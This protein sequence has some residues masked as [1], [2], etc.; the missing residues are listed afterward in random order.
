MDI[1]RTKITSLS[2]KIVPSKVKSV[3]KD[4]SVVEYLAELHSKFA[5]V[6]ID[7]AANNISIICKRFYLLRIL[8]ELG[9]ADTPS[10]TYSLSQSTALSII[11]HNTSLCESYHLKVTDKMKT[12]PFIYW[13]PKMHYSPS[14]CRFILASS[15]CSTKPLSQTVSLIFKKIFK[16]IQSFHQRSY[17]YRN[18]N[19]FWVVENSKPV[20][21]R[22]IKLNQ[23]NKAKSISTFDFSTLYTK[24]PHNNLVEVLNSLVDFV[25]DGGLKTVGGNRKYLTVDGKKCYFANTNKIPQSYTKAQIHMMVEHLIT[26]FFFSFGNLVFQQ[27]IGIPMG[28][29]PA[30]FWAN[31]YLYHFE[32]EFVLKL[33]RIDRYRGFKFKHCFRFIDDACSINDSDEF[34]KSYLE[35]YPP[36]LQLKCEH[37]GTHA[38]F[39]ELDISIIDG[40][41]VYKLYDKRDAFPFFIV[42]MPDLSGNLPEKIFYS[43]IGSEMLRIARATLR[44]EHFKDKAIALITRMLKQGAYLTKIGR[45]LNK[46][47]SR[48]P[49]AFRSFDVGLVELKRDILF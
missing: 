12:L 36:E 30:P 41:F 9:L 38:T 21:E 22:M 37:K 5:L 25:F 40:I 24:L 44:Y 14:R 47:V 4:P 43:A 13:T 31:L 20:L 34:D 39:L 46:V 6:P 28:I 15:T 32:S 7:K 27:C 23:G 1:V 49:D 10:Q 33:S 19:R 18:Y 11:D 26:Q 17:F 2:A 35:I 45:C 16:Q 42:R 48:H 3:L 29:D 8:K